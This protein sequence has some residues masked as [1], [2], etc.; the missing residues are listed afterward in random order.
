M[1]PSPDERRQHPRQ[2]AHGQVR[3]ATR[4]G[5]AFDAEL[6]D[7]SLSGMRVRL[8]EADAVPVELS[9][10]W[11]AGAVVYDARVVWRTPPYVG[12][13]IRRTV[14]MRSPAG[15]KDLEASRLWREHAGRPGA[16]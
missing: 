5:H 9:I 12:L 11:L 2:S 7:R 14:D 6:I 4:S 3:L 8:N 13:S 15:A 16:R 1:G 10:V